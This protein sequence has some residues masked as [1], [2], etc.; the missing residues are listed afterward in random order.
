MST[1]GRGP[2]RSRAAMIAIALVATVGGCTPEPIPIE[3]TRTSATPASSATAAASST[4]TPDVPG[5]ISALP[6]GTKPERPA[7]LDQAGSIDA[8][9]AVL[10]YWIYLLPYS[11]QVGDPSDVKALSHP[12]CTFCRSWTDALD[13]MVA[14]NERA[15]GG[16]YTVSDLT[17]LEVDL[18]RWYTSTFT[19]TEAPST[20]VNEFGTTIK[21]YP[22]HTYKV[23]AIV[24]YESGAWTVRALAHETVS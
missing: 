21:S 19:L 3:P 22:G 15:V 14:R 5:E 24:V 11:Q 12:D 1:Q 6:D 23:D 10:M 17:T 7:A 16:G 18:G 2:G 13:T 8:A 4:P 9:Q 20:E